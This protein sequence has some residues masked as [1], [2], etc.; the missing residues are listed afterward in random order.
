[1]KVPDYNR[2]AWD[3]EVSRG[4]PWTIPVSS[5][6]VARAR[7]GDWKIYLTPSPTPASWLPPMDGRDVLCLASGGGQQGPILAAAGANVTVFDNSS[8]QLARDRMVAQRDNL[9][10]RTVQ[11]D[12]AD[13]S[14]FPDESF[15]LIV[16]P[17]SNC[18][19]PAVRPVW[20]ECYRVLRPGGVLLAG[21][22]NPAIYLFD[23]PLYEQGVFKVRYSLPYSD[24]TSPTEEE[25]QKYL[26]S[27]DP[28][29]F[30][31]MLTDQ[32]G[33]QVDAGFLIAG[34]YEDYAPD[35]LMAQYMP[36]FIAT[37]AFK[38]PLPKDWQAH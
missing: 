33:G 17:V 8:Q 34:L 18:F 38:P 9:A 24:L 7:Q 35:E 5:E 2:N 30:G 37:R 23:Y 13:L 31:H 25:R 19:V 4:N 11:G 10:I 14:V 1:M 20:A 6:E 29:E 32:I 36:S 22:N 26:E 3:R 28:L 21:F 16:H 12:M 15:N 27:G